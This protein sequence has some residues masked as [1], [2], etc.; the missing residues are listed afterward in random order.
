MCTAFHLHKHERGILFLPD[1]QASELRRRVLIDLHWVT[2]LWGGSV[3]STPE[4]CLEQ[5]V[6][7][8]S[9]A[10]CSWPAFST[11]TPEQGVALLGLEWDCSMLL[12][13]G[14]LREASQKI[15]WGKMKIQRG[16]GQF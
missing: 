14:G 16:R 9:A 8:L 15:A 3:A 4:V 5:G 11:V 1:L 6:R 12:D 7:A 10:P 13:C 2:P